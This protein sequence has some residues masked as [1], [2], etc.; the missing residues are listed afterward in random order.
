MF[1]VSATTTFALRDIW[2]AKDLGD[3]TGG[4][5]AT[6]P[7]YATAYLVLTPAAAGI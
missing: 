6:V 3:Y 1:N 4:Y 7:S 5:T 2:A